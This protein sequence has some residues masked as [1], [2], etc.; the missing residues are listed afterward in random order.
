MKSTIDE[1]DEWL[2]A[3]FAAIIITRF[4]RKIMI[5]SKLHLRNALYKTRSNALKYQLNRSDPLTFA[6]N[7]NFVIAKP[8]GFDYFQALLYQHSTL[9]DKL[10]FWRN[11][12]ELRRSYSSYSNDL[13]MK[14]LIESQGDIPKASI[15]L[16]NQGFLVNNTVTSQPIIVLNHSMKELFLPLY[17]NFEDQQKEVQQL[18][19]LLQ[20]IQESPSKTENNPSE[21]HF[22]DNARINNN[23]AMI[24]SLKSKYNQRLQ[25][26]QFNSLQLKEN[27]LKSE[28]KLL[29]KKSDLYFH[30]IHLI[31]RTFLPI[32][33]AAGSM[34]KTSLSRPNSANYKKTKR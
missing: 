19:K 29:Q 30:L 32:I 2:T 28:L 33:G 6:R 3:N 8:K 26:N 23:L 18:E 27:D 24:R 16:E 5:E 4:F 10:Q 14:A 34:N 11:I 25:Q 17:E 31:E 20:T 12:I 9:N 22:Y 15:L 13:L 21:D 1:F 7:L